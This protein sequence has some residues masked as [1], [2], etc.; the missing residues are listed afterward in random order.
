[1]RR[2]AGRRARPRGRAHPPRHGA[3]PVARAGR[4]AARRGCVVKPTGFRP[5]LLLGLVAVACALAALAVARHAA[6]R[7]T[8]RRALPALEGRLVVPGLDAELAIVR[9]VRGIPHVRAASERDAYFGLGFA[10]AQDRLAQMIWLARAARGRTAEVIGS[11]GLVGDRWSRTLGFARLA[12]ARVAHLDP[13]MRR[14]LEAYAAGTNAWIEE[15]RQ[16]RA[17]VPV[18]L[19]RLRVLLEP[20]PPAYSIAGAKLLAW[21]LDGST[22]ASLVLSDL[23]ERLGGFGARPFFPPEAAGELAPLPL[24]KLETRSDGLRDATALRRAVGLV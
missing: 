17:P 9:D 7:R 2:G 20:W 1:R 24:P 19:A 21:A 15:I 3:Q 16:G 5:W 8:V 13:A 18:P 23:I 12:D 22:D 6:E 11:D 10:H 4:G 14:L